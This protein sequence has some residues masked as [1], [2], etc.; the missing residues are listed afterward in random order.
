MM[1]LKRVLLVGI[2]GLVLALAAA[3]G[4][5]EEPTLQATPVATPVAPTPAPTQIMQQMEERPEVMSKSY[6]SYPDMVID[7]SKQ[8]TAT[9]KTSKGTIVLEL[10]AN[11]A[12]KTVNNFV[13]LAREGFYDG[14]IFHRVISGFMIQGGDPTGTG[15]SG[16]GYR[17]DDE[18]VNRQYLA[19]TLAMANAG[20]DTNGSQF[21]IMHNDF[22]LPPNYTIFGKATEGQDVVNA[23]ATTPTSPTDR[24]LED[25]YIVSVTIEESDG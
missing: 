7:E 4:G 2:A 20:P 23:I 5:D 12:P 3:C 14:V 11:E 17:F 18:P 19:G 9:V 16:P 22:R 10:F 15:M 24:P 8:Y 1:S 6:D 13:F 21:F 25:V